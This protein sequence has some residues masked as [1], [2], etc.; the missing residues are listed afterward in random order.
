MIIPIRT[1]Y[2]M[3]RRPWVNYALVAANVVIHLYAQSLD[4]S[5]LRPFLLHPDAPRL[6]QFFSSVFL[7]ADLLHIGGNMVF[8]WVFG[9]ALNDRFGH[10]AYL[11]FYLA[12][13]VLAGV[14]YV[15]LSG[16]APV[17]GASGAICAVTGAYLVLFPRVRV[18]VLMW[19]FYLI[20]RLQV[21]SLVF[22]GFQFLY[23]LLMTVGA[24]EGGVAYAAHTSGY[25]YGIAIS[26][27]LLAFKVV[28]RDPMD[29]LNLLGQ[30]RR[31][32]RYRRMVSQGYNPFRGTGPSRPAAEGE[33]A[34]RWVETRSIH[35]SQ[36]N[37]EAA[38]ELALRREISAAC[39]RHDLSTAAAK[40]LQLVQIADGA[41]LGQQNQLDVA[42]QLM[43][44]EQYPAAADAYE[45]FLKHYRT[46]EHAADIHLMLGLLYGRY[47]HQYDRAERCLQRAIEH[48]GD[49]GKTEMA[50]AELQQVRQ[51]RGS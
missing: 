15:L 8:L 3:T 2:R 36:P 27:I 21:S 42:N 40:Y 33:G 31:R 47:L 25:L 30:S 16:R 35:S 26:L 24:R 17:L 22:V 4:A 11:A 34:G 48:L 6:H 49:P 32:Q 41:V 46:Y 1:D 45:R 10:A 5:V 18:T 19:I 13:G 44:A 28:P 9:N 7:H 43:S 12:G 20:T 37:T 38:R 50:R 51:R 29:L 39:G 14:G 23:N